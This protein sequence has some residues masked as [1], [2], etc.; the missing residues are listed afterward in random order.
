MPRIEVS[1]ELE[2]AHPTDEWS[3]LCLA[4]LK[5]GCEWKLRLPIEQETRVAG[6]H[7]RCKIALE[8]RRAS[9]TTALPAVKP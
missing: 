6:L 5:E 4:C 2:P 1:L 3:L 8:T 7:S 9:S